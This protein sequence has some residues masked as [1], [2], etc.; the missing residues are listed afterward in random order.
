MCVECGLCVILSFERLKKNS[1]ARLYVG[2]RYSWVGVRS[3]CVE[4][5]WLC[6]G[7]A[8]TFSAYK[9]VGTGSKPRTSTSVHWRPTFIS[10]M[11]RARIT[12]IE[13]RTCLYVECS[14]SVHVLTRSVSDSC[15][16]RASN[17]RGILHRICSYASTCTIFQWFVSDCKWYVRDSCAI[18]AWFVSDF[19]PRHPDNFVN[20]STHNHAQT[21]SV[22]DL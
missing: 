21:L 19:Y 12:L 18:H 8:S 20:F 22:R 6:A 2:V 5:A 4:Y 15:V 3:L 1:A 9:C 17:V 16:W 13:E 10:R 14:R 7:H 11:N